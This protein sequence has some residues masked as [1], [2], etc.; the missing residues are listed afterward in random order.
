MYARQ[1]QNTEAEERAREIRLRAERKCG[2]K[3]TEI[4]RIPGRRTDLTSSHEGKRSFAEECERSRISPKQAE[5]WQKLAAVPEDLFE[6]ALAEPNPSTSGIITRHEVLER[7]LGLV[8]NNHQAL[9]L[10]GCLQDFER[11][12]ILD[13][14]PNELIATM[15]DHMQT[16]TR[17]L[18]PRVMAWL[19][20]IG[21]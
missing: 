5:N 12:G 2:Q 17:D 10:W 20:R 15:L 14:D 7:P 13:E 19:G 6:Q 16:T 9:W 11:D 21:K 8:M 1:A 3:L 4:D 18:V